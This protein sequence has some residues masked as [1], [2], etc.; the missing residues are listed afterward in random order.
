MEGSIIL[1]SGAASI[2]LMI[3]VGL[4]VHAYRHE[5]RTGQDAWSYWAFAVWLLTVCG[6]GY[7]YLQDPTYGPVFQSFVGFVM[8]MVFAYLGLEI[9][10]HLR[11]SLRSDQPPED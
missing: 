2:I 10:H 11:Q 7:F 3:G 1:A 5:K 8:P 4:W 9:L 6:T